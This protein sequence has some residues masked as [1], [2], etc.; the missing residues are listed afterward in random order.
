MKKALACALTVCLALLVTEAQ[1]LDVNRKVL[2]NGLTLLHAER[3]NLPLVMVTLLVKAGSMDEPAERAGLANLAAGLLTEGTK[4]RSSTELSEEVAFIGA[5]LGASAGAD[6]STITLS[7]L[8]KHVEKGFELFSE[9]L[10]EPTFPPGEIRR[11]KDLIKASLMQR[12]EAPSFLA[13]R[14]FIKAVYGE[15]PYGRLLEGAPESLEKITRDEI[16]DFHSKRFLPNNSI[17]SVVGDLGPEELDGLVESYLGRWAKKPVPVR[18]GF[19]L[20]PP[21][22]KVVKIDRDLTQANIL[23]GHAGLGRDHPDYY[24]L[25]VMNYIL[26]GGGFSSR[27]MD[28]VRDEMGLAYSIYSSASSRMESG[29]FR[30][31]AQTKNASANTVIKEIVE[32]MKKM[33]EKKVTKEEL[34]DARSFLIGSF[35]R[36]LDTMRKIADFL[37][38]VEFYG[39]GPDYP[40]KYRQYIS[41]VTREDILMAAKKHL[42]PDKYVLVVVASQSEAD[43]QGRP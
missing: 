20:P 42:Y 12:E 17:L 31:V 8:K 16:V 6:Y 36:R 2:E 34:E 33:R 30:V 1:A 43:V 15:H 18:G 13:S 26:G 21:E 40:E 5:K 23:L 27:L 11:R 41:G 3:R 19:P 24:A 4:N 25:S 22:R 29:D 10:I 39:L 28:T 38:L 35:P 7:V 32:Q 14:A 37:S 9:V